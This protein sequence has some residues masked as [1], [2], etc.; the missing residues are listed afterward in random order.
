M[1]L[2]IT[3]LLSL[4]LLS[5]FLFLF[6]VFSNSLIC[7][8]HQDFY[9]SL[10]A[11]LLTSQDVLFQSFYLAPFSVSLHDFWSIIYCSF[12][13]FFSQP[14]KP[15]PPVDTIKPVPTYHIHRRL[16]PCDFC[17]NLQICKQSRMSPQRN[18]PANT[19]RVSQIPNISSHNK[20]YKL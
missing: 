18:T 20:S 5:P 9:Y 19:F 7:P 15:Q 1:F 11:L 2:F 8:R 12:F 14:L 13:L 17:E 3:S 4:S 16:F 6:P 10:P